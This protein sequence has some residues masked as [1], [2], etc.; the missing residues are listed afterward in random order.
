MGD[1]PTILL[2]H[3]G[4]LPFLQLFLSLTR[5]GIPPT[6]ASIPSTPGAFHPLALHCTFSGRH[7]TYFYKYFTLSRG[8]PPIRISLPR[9][10][11]PPTFTI[12]WGGIPPPAITRRH[13]TYGYE[14]S[15]DSRGI[16]PISRVG[17]PPTAAHISLTHGALHPFALC[18][19]RMYNHIPLVRT[20]NPPTHGGSPPA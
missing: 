11:I 2:A 4:I 12:H 17:T 20:A 14:Y 1:P 15:T 18:I 7:S 8:T 19:P 9:T 16:P 3:V 5:V 6:F 13:S 10:G